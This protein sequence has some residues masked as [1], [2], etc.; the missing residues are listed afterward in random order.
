MC[1]LSIFHFCRC[2]KTLFTLF[3]LPTSHTRKKKR[4]KKN[5]KKEKRYTSIYRIRNHGIPIRS[6]YSGLHEIRQQIFKWPMHSV[7]G[8]ELG[9]DKIVFFAAFSRIDT[10]NVLLSTPVKRSN[11]TNHGQSACSRFDL[12]YVKRDITDECNFR[13]T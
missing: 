9:F 5:R 10:P 7:P 12:Y 1:V 4:K 11:T 6:Q 2:I 3:A 13:G 8:K